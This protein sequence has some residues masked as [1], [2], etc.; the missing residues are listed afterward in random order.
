MVKTE[1]TTLQNSKILLFDGVCNLCNNTVQFI[2]KRDK[3]GKIQFASL[4]SEFGQKKT[5][6]A[7]LPLEDLKS[8][9]FIENGTIYTRSTGA[10][11]MTKYLDGIWKIAYIFIIIPRPIR[12]FFYNIIAA[13]RYRWFGKSEECMMPTTDIKSRFIKN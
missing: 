12:D 6:E 13:N 4:Q 10:L 2:I 3:K 8:I 7:N 11:K 5:L 9:I 1:S